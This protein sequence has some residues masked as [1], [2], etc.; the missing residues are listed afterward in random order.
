MSTTS[1]EMSINKCFVS[2]S[3]KMTTPYPLSK[4]NAAPTICVAVLFSRYLQKYRCYEIV[5]YF[6]GKL[7]LADGAPQLRFRP[8]Q[9]LFIELPVYSFQSHVLDGVDS[10]SNDE[11]QGGNRST[12][13]VARCSK[14]KTKAFIAYG[15]P[16][17][18]FN[19]DGGNLF[20]D[21]SPRRFSSETPKF[22][23]SSMSPYENLT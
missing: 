3:P 23:T 19:I 7:Y 16:T 22:C 2:R 11:P 8:T 15:M 13:P 1:A 10:S 17:G 9:P 14:T 12:P 5:W 21:Q 6:L 18:W 4:W 20:P